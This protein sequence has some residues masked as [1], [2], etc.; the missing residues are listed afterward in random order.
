[1]SGEPARDATAH[2]WRTWAAPVALAV[3]LAVATAVIARAALPSQESVWADEPARPHAPVTQEQVPALVAPSPTASPLP[4]E[5]SIEV[6]LPPPP[7]PPVAPGARGGSS[8][9]RIHAGAGVSTPAAWCDGG[10][11]ATASASS[12]GGLLAAAN[13]ERARWGLAALTWS[14]SLASSAVSW[15]QSQASSGTLSHGDMPSPG[16]Q[17]VAYRYSSAGQSEGGAAAWAHPAWMSSAGHCKNILNASW[18]TMGAGAATADGG[19]T[20]YLTANFQ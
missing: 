7:P 18:R 2:R 8:E 15:S 12:V 5:P 16:G 19:N 4:Y 9:R 14:S 20:W 10:Y 13:A 6:V 17:N 11:G 3:I 1:M